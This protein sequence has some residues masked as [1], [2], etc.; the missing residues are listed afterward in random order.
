MQSILCLG[1]ELGFTPTLGAVALGARIVERH[2]T[3]DKGQRG[4][5]HKCSLDFS[6]FRQMVAAIRTLEVAL[7][8]PDKRFL[9][10]ERPCFDKLGKSVVA[11][12]DLGKGT[13]LNLETDLCIKVRK[14]ECRSVCMTLYIF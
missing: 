1:H 8:S 14:K 5:D 13:V 3:L 4:S 11:S 7:G 9:P 12:K 6:E 2:F 10:C